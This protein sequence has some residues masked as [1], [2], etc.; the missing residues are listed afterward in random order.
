MEVQQPQVG[1]QAGTAQGLHG[2]EQ[3]RD[4]EAE[5]GPLPHRAAPAAGTAGGELG[6]DADERCC[7]Q[8]AAGGDDPLHFIGLLD[9][10]HRLAAEAAGQDRRFDVAA[11]LVAV[12]DQQSLGV[13][14][15]GEGNQQLRLAAGLQAEVP[16][17]A[18]LHQLLHHMALLVALH[19]KHALV[20]AAVGV[21][22]D[23][24]LE[25]SVKPLQPVFE[26]VVEADQQRQAEVAALQLAH[27][28]HQIQRSASLAAGLHDHVAPLAH[29]EVRIAPAIDA[30]EGGPVGGAP[31]GAR[32]GGGAGGGAGSGLAVAGV[33]DGRGAGGIGEHHGARGGGIAVE[34]N[35][36]V[37]FQPQAAAR[38]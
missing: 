21:L 31:G 12:A 20:A 23:G 25:G 38:E 36:G 33:G 4:R 13:V 22:G 19:R 10:H 34:P 30:V 7:P 16:A 32:G 17:A 5:L 14:E 1:Q 18:A 3:I 24:A 27:Q 8:L 26:D 11:V 35:L 2:G 29:G 6:A 37:L 9:H 28:V 15:Q